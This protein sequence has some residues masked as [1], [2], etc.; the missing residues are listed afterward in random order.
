MNP[1]FEYHLQQTRRQFF[2]SVGLSLGG[3][4]LSM[5]A[6]RAQNPGAN[7][8]GSPNSPVHPALPGL[9]HFAPRA[10]SLIYLHMNGA[11]SQ[12][13]LWDHKPQMQRYFDQNL[14]ESVR[15]G[16]RLSTMTSGQGRHPVGAVSEEDDPGFF[17]PD[18]FEERADAVKRFGAED[19]VVTV[20]VINVIGDFRRPGHSAC[21]LVAQ[22]F[23]QLLPGVGFARVAAGFGRPFAPG[24]LKILAERSDVLFEHGFGAALAALVRRADIVMRAVQAHPQ[25]GPAF[26]AALPASRLPAQGPRLAA[27]V[28]MISHL[29]F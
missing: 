11:P 5:C 3:L 1:L 21:G 8:P 26:Q 24:K 25:V 6:G 19:L 13:D 10:K 22:Q 20:E 4:A 17:G 18:L 16:Q 2:G 14:P 27:I 23:F 7:A 12:I 29:R 15:M 9:P 28:A